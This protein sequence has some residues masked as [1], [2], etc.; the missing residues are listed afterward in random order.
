MPGVHGRTHLRLDVSVR[1][2]FDLLRAWCG[3]GPGG[4]DS[5]QAPC[6]R[7]A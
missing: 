6:R 3:S 5:E 4:G 1:R 7:T 2:L